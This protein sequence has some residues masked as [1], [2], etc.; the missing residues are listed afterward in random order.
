VTW[1]ARLVQDAP[2]SCWPNSW[3]EIKLDFLS[4]VAAATAWR[5]WARE[6]DGVRAAVGAG[7]QAPGPMAQK[8]VFSSATLGVAS[9]SPLLSR[10]MQVR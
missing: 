7:T 2:A 3:G 5:Q 8:G 10:Q 6:V 1:R 9:N 4:A